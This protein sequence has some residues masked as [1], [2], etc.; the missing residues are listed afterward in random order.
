MCCLWVKVLHSYHGTHVDMD[1]KR[2][3]MRLRKTKKVAFEPCM[4]RVDADVCVCVCVCVVQ[5]GSRRW[6]PSREEL[7]VMVKMK[8]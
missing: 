3:E 2:V 4:N 5:L 8:P 7:S 6:I 1:A